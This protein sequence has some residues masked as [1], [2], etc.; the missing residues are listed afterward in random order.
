MAL[1][2]EIEPIGFN[3]LAKRIKDY[4][5]ITRPTLSTHLKHLAQQG[6]ITKRVET[7]SRLHMKPSFYSVNNQALQ[8]HLPTKLDDKN[9]LFKLFKHMDEDLEE[10]D[11]EQFATSFLMFVYFGDLVISKLYFDFIRERATNNKQSLKTLNIAIKIMSISV[12]LLKFK[13]HKLSKK[14]RKE[15][16][17]KVGIMFDRQI[18]RCLRFLKTGEIEDF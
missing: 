18:E 10:I 15:D 14:A 8:K 4:A 16:M 3:Q 5:N 11:Y 6:L 1:I 17:E 2:N 7:R 12:D 9:S 13:L